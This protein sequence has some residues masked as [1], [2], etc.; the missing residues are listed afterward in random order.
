MTYYTQ[1]IQY[2]HHLFLYNVHPWIH[3]PKRSIPIVI[4]CTL[5]AVLPF[6][7]VVFRRSAVCLYFFSRGL[8]LYRELLANGIV[9]VS[10]LWLWLENF[11]QKRFFL[12]VVKAEG[13]FCCC[14]QS[15][16]LLISLSLSAKCIHFEQY[17]V[18]SIASV[19]QRFICGCGFSLSLT[20][21]TIPKS[22]SRHSTPNIST[23]LIL[24][25]ER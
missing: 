21:I 20:R 19:E 6:S 4:K 11:P 18:I 16:F 3:E 5:C 24:A 23:L 22:T 8:A 7:A 1:Y 25:S 14:S 15:A 12:C 9:F 2:T 10:W 13:F 17:L